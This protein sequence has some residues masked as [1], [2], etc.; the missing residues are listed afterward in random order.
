MTDRSSGYER[1]AAEF[2]ASRGRAPPSAIGVSEAR[3]WGRTLARGAAVLD[4]GCGPGIPITQALIDEGLSV[5]GIDAAPSFVDAFRRNLPG[6]PVACETVGDS[7]FFDRQF[8]GVIAWGLMFLLDEPAQRHLLRSMAG[9][10]VPGGRLL[11]TSPAQVCS[12][13]DVMTGLTSR[14]LGAAEYRRE[15]MSAGVRIRA[16]YDDVG[17]NHYYD[18]VKE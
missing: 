3:A 9:L 4:L 10:L 18:A 6:V 5:Y 13:D 11:F 2:L 15:L 7:T 8:D 17:Q 16:E 12:W 14:S 1:V